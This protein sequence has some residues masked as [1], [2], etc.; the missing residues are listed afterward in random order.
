MGVLAPMSAHAG[1]SAQPPMGTSINFPVHMSA[2]SSSN[3]SPNPL[4][5]ISEVSELYDKPF[6]DIFEIS[7]LSG[8]NRVIWG[9]MG[10][11]RN[12]LLIG[13]FQFVLLGSPCKNL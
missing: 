10:G 4:E 7:Q 11:P 6:L 8:Q 12:F 9:E 5:V 2:E 1:P 13:I 3:I